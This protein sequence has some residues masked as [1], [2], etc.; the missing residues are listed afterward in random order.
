MKNKVLH[1]ASAGEGH[2]SNISTFSPYHKENIFLHFK[3][4]FVDAVY[5]NISEKHTNPINILYG[6]NAELMIVKVG[7]FVGHD[8]NGF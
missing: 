6:H 8:T 5:V 3:D 2:L 4:Q 1:K 7:G